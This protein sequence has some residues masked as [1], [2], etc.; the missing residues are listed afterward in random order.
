M[1]RYISQHSY[2]NIELLAGRQVCKL[3]SVVVDVRDQDVDG[4]GGVEP[5]AALVGHHHSQAVLAVVLP[6]QRHPVNNFT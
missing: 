3:W 6:V 2:L 1:Y 4:G 5:R